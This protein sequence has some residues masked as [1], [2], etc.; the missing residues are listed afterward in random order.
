MLEAPCTKE[1]AR[2][3]VTR[4]T[5]YSHRICGCKVVGVDLYLGVGWVEIIRIGGP[6]L[7]LPRACGVKCHSSQA[8]VRVCAL[9][10][11]YRS[12]CGEARDGFRYANR[13]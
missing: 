1:V 13:C 6:Q 12:V 10:P 4:Y 2:L 8:P 11:V 3:Y 9:G 5:V 7:S